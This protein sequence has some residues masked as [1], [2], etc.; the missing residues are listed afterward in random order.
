MRNK[1]ATIAKAMEYRKTHSVIET[2]RMFGVTTTTVYAWEKKWKW[3]TFNTVT[4]TTPITDR[5]T[6]IIRQIAALKA[7]LGEIAYTEW[8]KAA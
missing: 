8:N 1:T 6:T 7:E 5:K 3:P 4:T 2:A